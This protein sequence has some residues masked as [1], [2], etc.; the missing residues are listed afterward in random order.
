MTNMAGFK[1]F[2]VVGAA[3]VLS[4]ADWNLENIELVRKRADLSVEVECSNLTFAAIRN[5][6]V[7]PEALL[8]GPN[9][10]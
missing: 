5:Q 4:L 3:A 2:C 9:D 6:I 10:S 8:C 7:M 1:E